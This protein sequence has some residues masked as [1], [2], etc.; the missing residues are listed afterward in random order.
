MNQSSN[1]ALLPVIMVWEKW[2]WKYW[3]WAKLNIKNSD[4][5]TY[6]GRYKNHPQSSIL[7]CVLEVGVAAHFINTNIGAIAPEIEGITFTNIKTVNLEVEFTA[8]QIT[9]ILIVTNDTVWSVREKSHALWSPYIYIYIVTICGTTVN[10][11]LH[12]LHYSI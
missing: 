3:L 4:H 10:S 1:G 11:L 8:R 6:C 2:L 9:T 7:Y 12:S 5:H